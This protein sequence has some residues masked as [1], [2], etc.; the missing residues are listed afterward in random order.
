[1]PD[2]RDAVCGMEFPEEGAEELGALKHEHEGKT[3]W[4]C[5]ETCRTEFKRAPER[6]SS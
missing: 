1:M 4:F 6:Y 5:C 3:Y 2:V